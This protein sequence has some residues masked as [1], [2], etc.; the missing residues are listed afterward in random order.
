MTFNDLNLKEPLL[1]AVNEMG[2]EQP[3]PIQE[4][5]IP[6]LLQGRDV[7]GQSHTGSGKTAR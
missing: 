7:L 6:A 1:R 2:F 3:S 4:E 5:A